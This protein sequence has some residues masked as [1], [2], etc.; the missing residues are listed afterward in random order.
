MSETIPGTTP[1]DDQM[2]CTVL[3]NVP[4]IVQP[5]QKRNTFSFSGRKLV[6]DNQFSFANPQGN[7][8]H[9][10]TIITG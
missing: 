1:M 10:D 3:D 8:N 2:G 6:S 4:P 7:D 9:P 5:T